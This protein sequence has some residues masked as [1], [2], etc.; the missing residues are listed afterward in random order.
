MNFVVSG[1]KFFF[2]THMRQR[3]GLVG[4]AFGTAYE[5]GKKSG[6]G[7]WGEWRE[8][9]YSNVHTMAQIRLG[10]LS[11]NNTAFTTKAT[12]ANDNGEFPSHTAHGM[13]YLKNRGHELVRQHTPMRAQKLCSPFLL[14]AACTISCWYAPQSRQGIDGDTYMR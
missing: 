6:P 4:T 13:F 9:L 12:T 2:Y 11:P 3:N 1:R 5:H 8:S 14:A 7:V 10:K